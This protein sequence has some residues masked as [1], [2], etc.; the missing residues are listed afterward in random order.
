MPPWSVCNFVKK[1]AIYLPET[2][3]MS[4]LARQAIRRGELAKANDLCQQG[5]AIAQ[6][7][8]DRRMESIQYLVWGNI[9]LAKRDFPAAVDHLETA[10]AI[11]DMIKSV[12]VLDEAMMLLGDAYR[13][14]AQYELALYIFQRWGNLCLQMNYKAKMATCLGRIANVHWQLNP[15]N[16]ASVHWLATAVSWWGAAQDPNDDSPIGL[17]INTMQT[18]L[19]EVEFAQSWQAGLSQTLK[20]GLVK[21]TSKGLFA[22]PLTGK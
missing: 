20:A 22:S 14:T 8:N 11:G 4:F 18:Q 15:G 19:T 13:G 3:A 9:D 2:Y 21:A 7:L 12:A 5:L 10:V 16:L 1:M 17:W 6:D